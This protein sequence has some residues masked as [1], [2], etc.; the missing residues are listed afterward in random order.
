MY[1]NFTFYIPRTVFGVG[2]SKKV[3]TYVK[4]LG[5]TKAL[6]LYDKGV[7]AAG[8][9]DPILAALA[10][11]GI[12]TAEFD[13]V[14]SDPTMECVDAAAALGAA[15][16]VDILIAVGGGSTIDTG[17]TARMLITNGGPGVQTEVWALSAYHKAFAD[18]QYGYGAAISLVLILVV[19]VLMLIIGAVM[20]RQ[21][22]ARL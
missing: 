2:E 16:H 13:G 12:A 14:M 8:V 17:K 18:S 11:D 4:K 19:M 7:K 3:G 21:E 9:V 5:G 10:A 1:N 15:E 22:K 20:R 6:V